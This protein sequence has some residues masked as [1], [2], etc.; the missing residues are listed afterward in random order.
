LWILYRGSDKF[1]I[2][3]MCDKFGDADHSQCDGFVKVF[4]IGT[5]LYQLK[6]CDCECHEK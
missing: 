1:M 5:A 4:R 6:R 3:P 2:N